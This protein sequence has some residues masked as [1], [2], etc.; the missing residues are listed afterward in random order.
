[1]KGRYVRLYSELVELGKLGLR[2]QAMLAQSKTYS[3][4]RMQTDIVA[5]ALLLIIAHA[6]CST[7]CEIRLTGI[8]GETGVDVS[9]ACAGS[10][11]PVPF[12]ASAQLLRYVNGT[13]GGLALSTYFTRPFLVYP[14]ELP[15]FSERRV[16]IFAVGALQP[17]LRLPIGLIH[18]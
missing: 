5:V 8:G 16:I 2:T 12:G 9:I 18:P 11:A 6:S 10:A 15:R 3:S 4:R 17:D 13:A 1:V 7:I 14:C